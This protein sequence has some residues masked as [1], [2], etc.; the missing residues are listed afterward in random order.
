MNTRPIL[1]AALENIGVPVVAGVYQGTAEEYIVYNDSDNRPAAYA[2]DT[3][4]WDEATVQVHYY[5]RTPDA[6]MRAKIKSRLRKAGFT[7]TGH[8][9]PTFE[10]DTK[11]YHLTVTAWID[12]PIE[13]EEE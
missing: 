10:S 9:G 1:K 11:F 12:G 2:D 13:T 3:D 7:I 8:Y 6:D 4:I 5:T